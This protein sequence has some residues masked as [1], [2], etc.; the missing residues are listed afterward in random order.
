MKYKRILVLAPHTDDAEL[1]CGGTIARFIEEGAEVYTAAF[2][3]AEESLPPGKPANTLLLEFQRSMAVLGVPSQNQ[4]VFR[5]P[6][7]TFSYERQ[8]ILEELVKLREEIKPDL[9][10]LPSSQ[11]I[12]QDHQVLHSEG[13]RAF[14]QVS[15]L[16][17]ESPWNQLTASSQALIKLEEKHVSAKWESLQ[18]YQS[19]QELERPYFNRDFIY[20]L[21][22]TR[23]IQMKT[24]WAEAF[25]VIRVIL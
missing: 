18:C 19:Q 9:V 11:D 12:H 25:E 2:S 7:R 1:G 14:K 24:K 4:S 21:A 16:G 17:Y 3:N 6:V 10:I 13:V 8:S 23:G 15:I 20:G 5:Y 22:V